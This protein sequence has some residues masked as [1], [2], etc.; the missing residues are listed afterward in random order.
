M[1]LNT[2]K[3]ITNYLPKIKYLNNSKKGKKTQTAL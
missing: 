1:A 3:I 2:N